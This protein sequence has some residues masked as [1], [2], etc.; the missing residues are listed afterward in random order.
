MEYRIKFKASAA[1]EFRKLPAN[2]QKR[3]QI[4]INA[5]RNDPRPSG[6]I[7]LKGSEQLYRI[8]LG[9]YRVVYSVDD[10]IQVI[11]ITRV[12]HRRDVYKD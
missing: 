9:D 5:L 4:P 1:K 7:K 11:F 12:R 8:R 3:L 2:I 6:S 10:T